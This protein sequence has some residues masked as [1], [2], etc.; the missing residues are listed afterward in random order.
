MTVDASASA[1]ASASAEIDALIAQHS[2]WRG[3]R[4]A[5]LRRIILETDP[6]IIETWKWMGSP[7]WE[8][9]GIICVGNLFKNKAK[10]TFMYGASLPDPDG[11]FNAELEGNQR[12]AIDYFEADAERS[13]SLHALVRSAIE[14]NRAKRVT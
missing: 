9:D 8:L 10:L 12:R 14:F 6:A 2:D 5:A 13:E 11:L 1:S 3:H 7:V 4:L